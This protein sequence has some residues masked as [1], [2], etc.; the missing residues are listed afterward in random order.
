[1]LYSSFRPLYLCTFAFVRVA[2][3]SKAMQTTAIRTVANSLPENGVILLTFLISKRYIPYTDLRKQCFW[4]IAGSQSL[5]NDVF[6][7]LR[8][9]KASKT[10][11]LTRRGVAKSKKRCFWRFAR[12]QSLKNDVFGVLQ[13]RKA[14]KT[15][16]LILYPSPFGD[17]LKQ[18]QNSDRI[19]GKKR[20][21]AGSDVKRGR[22]APFPGGSE[23]KRGRVVQFPGGFD[24]TRGRNASSPGG[25]GTKRGR[26]AP[27]PSGSDAARGRNTPEPGGDAVWLSIPNA[28]RVINPRVSTCGFM[29]SCDILG[30]CDPA[31]CFH[32]AFLHF[33]RSQSPKMRH[34]HA[35]RGRKTFSCD[36]LAFC[37]VAKP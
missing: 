17:F 15:M 27:F 18:R 8:G 1:M 31:K 29:S 19:F 21:S 36:I 5:E 9:R 33:A 28:M 35:F 10:M 37:G 13:G 16:F 6:G 7:V 4:R 30:L 3:T 20:L 22:N 26:V 25:F 34:F 23:A 32:A 12:S 24:A 2:R 14:L 11:F